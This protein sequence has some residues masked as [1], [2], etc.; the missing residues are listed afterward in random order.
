M[1]EE[2]IFSLTQINFSYGE[3]RVLHNINLEVTKGEVIGIIGP[4]GSGKST[5]LKVL[6]GYL[7]PEDGSVRF[8]NRDLTGYNK[9]ELARIIATL[10]QMLDIPFPY[11][12]HEFVMMGRYPHFQ[13]GFF[14]GIEE[15]KIVTDIL[16]MMEIAHLQG[17][18]IDALSEGERQRVYLAQCIAQEPEVILLDEPVSHLDIKHQM[19]TLEFLDTLHRDGLTILMVL[20]DLNLASEFCTRIVLLSKG[21]LYADGTPE[22]VLTYQN[23]EVV[24]DTIILVRENPLSKKPFVIPVPKQYLK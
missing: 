20:H 11:T 24:Y 18:K 7:A 8:L 3:L 4:N 5:L 19:R 17:R 23:I 9:K 22:V 1:K 10:P 6:A 14:Y 16:E 13:K 12:V 15:K 2:T 21:Y